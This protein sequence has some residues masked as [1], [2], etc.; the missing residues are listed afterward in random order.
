MAFATLAGSLRIASGPGLYCSSR[1][2]KN[3][4][5]IPPGI[6]R[7]TLIRPA[8]SAASA[9]VKPTTPNFAAQ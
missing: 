3:F 5:R 1:S 7:V 9:R 4:V 2:S 6:S 8:V